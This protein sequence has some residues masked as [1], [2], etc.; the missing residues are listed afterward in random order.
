L[1]TVFMSLVVLDGELAVPYNPRSAYA[2]SKVLSETLSSALALTG[3][4]DGVDLT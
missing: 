2:G 1:I 3:S 4:D